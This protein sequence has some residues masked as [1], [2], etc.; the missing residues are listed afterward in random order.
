MSTGVEELDPG[1]DC[2]I[3]WG[4][5]SGRS[6][7]GSRAHRL[8]LQRERTRHGQAVDR[9]HPA[10]ASERQRAILATESRSISSGSKRTVTAFFD[11]SGAIMSS[12][13]RLPSAYG[14][15]RIV[16]RDGESW[17]AK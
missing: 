2:K 5:W 9:P 6:L 10:R 3:G 7:P 14:C 16:V 11:A 1:I 17:A 15:C 13:A 8:D 12:T 4:S